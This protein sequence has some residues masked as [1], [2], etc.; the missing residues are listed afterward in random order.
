[1]RSRTASITANS[2]FTTAVDPAS[3]PSRDAIQAA[4]APGAPSTSRHEKM[5]AKGTFWSISSAAPARTVIRS[6]AHSSV[7]NSRR[8]LLPTPGSPSIVII[9]P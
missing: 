8:A 2:G 6:R 4:R 9:R 1:M 5:A 7:T 3:S